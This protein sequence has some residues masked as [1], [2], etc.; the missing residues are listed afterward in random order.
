[1]ALTRELR[2]LQT[3]SPDNS[4]TREALR[5]LVT[6][7]IRDSLPEVTQAANEGRAVIENAIAQ[8]LTAI[9]D[10]ATAA[11][12]R[13]KATEVLMRAAEER[14][15]TLLA[16]G[17]E[18]TKKLDEWLSRTRKDLERQLRE[19]WYRRAVPGLIA[20]AGT[21]IGMLLL[22]TLVRP[23]WTL[24]PSQREMLRIG[25]SVEQIYRDATPAEQ[26][27][28]RR[29]NHWQTVT[30]DSAQTPPSPRSS[31]NSSHR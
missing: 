8:W 11:A 22:L 20:G 12:E 21:G 9:R 16:H 26:A 1:M 5:A 25:E 14:T 27:E 30:P 23:G 29:V 13:A 7:A 31:H 6:T 17:M 4:E 10:G 3:W 18:V 28:M 24:S 15:Q 19:P 2:R